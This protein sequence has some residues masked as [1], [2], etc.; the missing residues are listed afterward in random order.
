MSA[1]E[2]R[3]RCQCHTIREGSGGVTF[4]YYMLGVLCPDCEAQMREEDFAE[5]GVEPTKRGYYFE[6]DE[7]PPPF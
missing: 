6:E 4:S 5:E 1:T 2:T 7:L 3:S